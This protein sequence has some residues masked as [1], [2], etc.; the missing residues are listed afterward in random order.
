MP[1]MQAAMR[2]LS[3]KNADEAAQRVLRSSLRERIELLDRKPGRTR[4]DA[5]EAGKLA[6]QVSRSL[7]GRN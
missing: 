7:S 4:A 5:R 2:W 3:G 6:R 1:E